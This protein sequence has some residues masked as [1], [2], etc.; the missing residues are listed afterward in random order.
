MRV[1]Q[2]INQSIDQSHQSVVNHRLYLHFVSRHSPV[3]NR[4]PAAICRGCCFCLCCLVVV[5]PY[6]ATQLLTDVKEKIIGISSPPGS[7]SRWPFRDQLQP[8][9][10][11][12]QARAALKLHLLFAASALLITCVPPLDGSWL[13]MCSHSH[14]SRL[15]C[16]L[17]PLPLLL[18]LLLLLPAFC[19]TRL[20]HPLP[21]V[22]LICTGQRERSTQGAPSSQSPHFG[23]RVGYLLVAPSYKV[24]SRGTSTSLS[25]TL[26]LTTS[27]SS[28][29]SASHPSCYPLVGLGSV[30]I[31]CTCYT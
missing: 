16:L 28:E 4:L 27:S 5:I 26:A 19:C 14:F 20:R 12:N 7:P 11:L 9:R 25:R 18:L 6:P 24:R 30:P 17:V 22:A 29:W 1:N 3:N 8:H 23:Y 21:Q 10:S 2:S 13:G 15:I 31:C